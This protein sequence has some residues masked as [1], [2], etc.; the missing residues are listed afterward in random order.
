MLDNTG[1]LSVSSSKGQIKVALMCLVGGLTYGLAGIGAILLMTYISRLSIGRDSAVSHGISSRDSSRLGGVAIGVIFGAYILGLM[2]FSPYTPGVVRLERE[3]FLWL[4]IF[5]SV[6]LGFVEDL[7]PDF[8][9]PLMRLIFKFVIW[10]CLLWYWPELIPQQ[11]GIIGFDSLLQ[12]PL[13][14]W[15]LTTVFCVGFI[16]AFNMADGA[17]GLVPGIAVVAFSIFFI[18]Y[19]RPT[20]GILMFVCT[21]FLIFNLISGWFFLGD[22]GSYGLGAIIL[23]YGLNGV[24]MEGFS[25]WFMMAMF[26]YPCLDFVV[27]IIR[28]LAI[29]GS[30]F[31]ADNGHLHNHLHRYLKVLFRSKV[32]ANSATGIIISGCTAGLVLAGY[33]NGWRAPQSHDWLWVFLL[34]AGLYLAAMGWLR[35]RLV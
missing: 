20:D 22:A 14:A 11:L 9:S 28:R 10:G 30:P 3:L 25:I 16:N 21:I 33:T 34:E 13:L 6:L 2:I 15:M 18:E 7:Q 19:S 27:S 17:N 12:I 5:I 29:G 4:A 1:L 23:G 31:A 26:A 35:P 24:A 8:L 32:L